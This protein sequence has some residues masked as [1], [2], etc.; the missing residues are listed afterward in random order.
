MEF[1]Y[2]LERAIESPEFG[3]QRFA[4]EV[5]SAEVDPRD[6]S[7][8]VRAAARGRRVSAVQAVLQAKTEAESRARARADTND[9]AQCE[10]GD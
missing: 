4:F 7:G 2:E 1:R 3:K 5:R 8:E 6:D 10:Q 9:G